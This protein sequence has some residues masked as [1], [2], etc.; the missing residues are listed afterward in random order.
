MP[1]EAPYGEPFTVERLRGMVGSLRPE[2]REHSTVLWAADEIERLRGLLAAHHGGM[3]ATCFDCGMNLGGPPIDPRSS[4][5]CGVFCAGV[6]ATW[7]DE[8]EACDV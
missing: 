8:E 5:R 7:T 3:W 6:E 1:D 4:T 2:I